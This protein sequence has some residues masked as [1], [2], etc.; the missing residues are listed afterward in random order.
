[1]TE[2]KNNNIEY[3]EDQIQVLE[4]LEAV[5]KRLHVYRKYILKRLH[6]CYEIVD[7]SIDESLADSVIK[8]M[9]F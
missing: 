2:N 8:Y 1:M 7:T 3:N 6:H 4:G 5:R 9:S